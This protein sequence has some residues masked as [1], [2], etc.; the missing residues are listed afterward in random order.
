[1]YC[2][3]VIFER[4]SMYGVAFLFR[5]CKIMET[6]TLDIINLRCDFTVLNIDRFHWNFAGFVFATNV[7]PWRGVA[8]AFREV[9]KKSCQPTIQSSMLSRPKC[10]NQTCAVTGTHCPKSK[11]PHDKITVGVQDPQDPTR[12]HDLKIQSPWDSV[13]KWNVT[14]KIRRISKINVQYPICFGCHNKKVLRCNIHRI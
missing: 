5:N 7:I 14:S 13:T 1:M 10:W 9:Q 12:K 8:A 6:S 11:G 2:K 4:R 3:I